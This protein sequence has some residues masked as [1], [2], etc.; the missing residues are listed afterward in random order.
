[1]TMARWFKH[2]FLPRWWVERPF[3]AATLDAIETAI[4]DAEVGHRGELRFVVEGPM[5]GPALWRGQTPRARAVALFSQLRVW[6]TEENSGVLIYVQLV[7]RRVEILADRGISARVP[8][9]EWDLLCRGLEL[10][11]KD[12]DFRRGSLEAIRQAARLLADHFPADGGS[13]KNELPD[14]PL[15]L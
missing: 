4:R 14:R 5:P 15:V 1:M 6:D 3:D 8:Q 12:R 7:D 9:G 10:S 13:G 11:F 2:L